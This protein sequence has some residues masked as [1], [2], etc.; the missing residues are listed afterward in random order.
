MAVVVGAELSLAVDTKIGLA[1]EEW[2]R[3]GLEVLPELS[4]FFAAACFEQEVCHGMVTRFSRA[5]RRFS[6][7]RLFGLLSFRG[8]GFVL[9]YRL[10]H[11]QSL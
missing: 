4:F 3:G 2:T 7:S 9:I 5:P 8:D 10:L 6:H 11:A 1:D